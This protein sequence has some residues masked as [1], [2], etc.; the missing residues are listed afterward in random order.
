MH[1]YMS[2]FSVSAPK[3]FVF[4]K[5]QKRSLS[6]WRLFWLDLQEVYGREEGKDIA[7]MEWPE[8]SPDARRFWIDSC[9]ALKEALKK[10]GSATFYP[11]H[12]RIPATIRENYRTR[13][14][15]AWAEMKRERECGVGLQ[16]T[17]EDHFLQILQETPR[18]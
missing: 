11:S 16:L 18:H 8:M 5:D 12:T 17:E 3:P 1:A 6:A 14:D 13:E 7:D 15:K 4:G 2:R 9:Q 10:D